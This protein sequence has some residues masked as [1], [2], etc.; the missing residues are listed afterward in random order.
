[1]KVDRRGMTGIVD[2]MVFMAIMGLAFAGLYAYGAHDAGDDRDAS[3]IVDCIMASA[4]L[5][6]D[7]AEAGESRIAGMADILAYATV[8]GDAGTVAY[9]EAV[10]DAA[11]GVPG[12]YLLTAGYDGHSL[13]AGDRHDS[14]RPTSV[15]KRTVPVTYGGDLTVELRLF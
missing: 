10:L 1:M 6:D 12:G 11:V 14:G 3:A 8:T 4:L 7:I 13:D 5:T 2:A 15:C 9:L